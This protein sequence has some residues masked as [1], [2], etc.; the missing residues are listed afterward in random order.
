ME[1]AAGALVVLVVLGAVVVDVVE[2]AVD[3]VVE[4]SAC[5]APA[6]PARGTDSARS[7]ISPAIH[8]CLRFIGPSCLVI[9][10]RMRLSNDEA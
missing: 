1:V 6:T 10:C 8:R 5:W 2:G 9:G 4:G 7:A 3:V